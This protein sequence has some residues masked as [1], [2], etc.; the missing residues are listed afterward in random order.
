M[1]SMFKVVGSPYATFLS[2]VLHDGPNA[3]FVEANE[4]TYV[5]S[6]SFG[7]RDDEDAPSGACPRATG[8]QVR[9]LE[10]YYKFPHGLI[11]DIF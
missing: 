4:M 2:T 11:V 5:N 7:E 8:A 10:A 9:E 6:D 3:R 1:V